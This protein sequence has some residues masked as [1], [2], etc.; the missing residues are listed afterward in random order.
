MSSFRQ[1]V[2]PSR[3]AAGRLVGKVRRSLQKALADNPAITQ[4]KIANDLNVHRSVINRQ[5]R[6]TQDM[7][8]GRVAELALALGYE[9]DFVLLETK[10]EPGQNV[11]PVTPPAMT[12]FTVKQELTSGYSKT[13]APSAVVLAK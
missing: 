9:A 7:T 8:I 10:A 4:T 2:T 11:D 13:W 1:S 5:L 12:P 6:G 3:R